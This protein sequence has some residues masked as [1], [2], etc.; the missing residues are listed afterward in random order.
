MK[1]SIYVRE[2]YWKSINIQSSPSCG[3]SD[4]YTFAIKNGNEI[5]QIHCPIDKYFQSDTNDIEYKINIKDE[6][7]AIYDGESLCKIYTPFNDYSQTYEQELTYKTEK[8]ED[9][10]EILDL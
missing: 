3:M 9:R 7:I 5:E 10:F 8:I 4:H 6:D 2:V 1:L